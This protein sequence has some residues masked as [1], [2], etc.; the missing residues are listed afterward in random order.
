MFRSLLIITLFLSALLSSSCRAEMTEDERIVLDILQRSQQ[1]NWTSAHRIDSLA[2]YFLETPY[3]AATLESEDG[4]ENLVINLREMDCMTFVENVLALHRLFQEKEAHH[5]TQ[6]RCLQRF[7]EILEN[8]RYRDGKR[9]DYSSRLH[10]TSEW[11]RNNSS[12]AYV[13]EISALYSDSVYRVHLDFMSTHPQLYKAL[14]LHPDLVAKISAIEASMEGYQ[15]SYIPKEDLSQYEKDIPSGR[16][17]A[18]V[19]S[20]PG[21]DFAHLGFTYRKDGCLHLLH[22]SSSG[23]KVMLSSGSLSDYLSDIK[24]FKGIVLLEVL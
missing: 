16:I 2:D 1:N 5:Y 4:E 23:K 24:R 20:T 8:I 6:A 3:V 17:V 13:K 21:L 18:I 12:K 10:Y 15:L 7:P 14:T 9:G 11:I 19:G 22:A